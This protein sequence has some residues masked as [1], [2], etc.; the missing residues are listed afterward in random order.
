[1]AVQLAEE[2]RLP[3]S[4]FFSRTDPSRNTANQLIPTIAYHPALHIPELKESIIH[5]IERHPL[6]FKL[7]LDAQFSSLLRDPIRNLAD[8]GFFDSTACPRVVII[9]G[10]DECQDPSAQVCILNAIFNSLRKTHLPLSFFITSCPDKRLSMA[11]AS[12]S[13]KEY[14]TRL[15]L[16]PLSFH[17]HGTQSFLLS[18]ISRLPTAAKCLVSISDKDLPPTEVRASFLIMRLFARLNLFFLVDFLFIN[19]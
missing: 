14:H 13:V 15:T 9:D 12:G 8:S 10:L 2:K 1:M 5:A 7:S 19:N 17:E 11:F 16:D 6:I 4:F 18:S 3:T